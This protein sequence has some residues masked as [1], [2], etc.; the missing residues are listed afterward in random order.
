MAE[1]KTRNKACEL[2]AFGFRHAASAD[3]DFLWQAGANRIASVVKDG[4]TGG[5]YTVQF[6]LPYPTALVGVWPSLHSAT[7]DVGEIANCRADLDS[8]DASLGT[9]DLEVITDDGDGTATIEQPIDNTAVSVL[10][11]AVRSAFVSDDATEAHA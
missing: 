3:P 8:Y 10:V 5:T 9:F 4:T 11:V 1:M 2:L 7:A 6:E